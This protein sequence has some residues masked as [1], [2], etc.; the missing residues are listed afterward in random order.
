MA[1]A[2]QR[3]RQ[4]TDAGW[5]EAAVP[6]VAPALAPHVLDYCGY[7]ERT[8]APHRRR[9]L[10]IGAI[11]LVVGFGP[12]LDLTYPQTTGRDVRARSFVAGAH[13]TWCVVESPGSQACVQV[14]LTPLGAHRLLGTAMHELANRVVDLDDLLGPASARL[15]EQLAE[16]P[17]WAE[18]LALVEAELAPR[19]ADAEQAAPDVDWA[20]RRLA[21]DERTAVGD[22]CAEIGCSR[23]H[24]ERRFRDRVGLSPAAYGRVVR[25]ERAVA[26]IDSRRRAPWRDS[27]GDGLPAERG[28]WGELALECGYFDQAHMN[29]DFRAFAGATPGQLAAGLEPDGTPGA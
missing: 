27:D 2:L 20:L 4:E 3:R 23:R 28:R 25:F 9:E 15:S 17:R 6:P 5:W 21:A 16:A 12:R 11:V 19:L 22:L 26:R 10:P 7:A 29:R 8:A 13:D 24:L 1:A 18:R 14:N